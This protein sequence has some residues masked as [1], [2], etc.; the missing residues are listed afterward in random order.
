[1]ANAALNDKALQAQKRGAPGW[2]SDGGSKGAGRLIAKEAVFYF[3][4]FRLVEKKWKRRFLTLGY[5]PSMSVR[6]ARAKAAQMSELLASGVTD[7]HAHFDALD[8]K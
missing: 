5:Y 6:E 4:Y 3:S 2:L 8:A 1:M 7:L